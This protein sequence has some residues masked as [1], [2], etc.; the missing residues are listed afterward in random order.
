MRNSALTIPTLLAAGTL[1]LAGCGSSTEAQPAPESTPDEAL[2]EPSSE[3][4]FT[5]AH[6]LP[7]SYTGPRINAP[8]VPECPHHEE[9][10]QLEE[11]SDQIDLAFELGCEADIHGEITFS[12]PLPGNVVGLIS[13]DD[14]MSVQ[15]MCDGGYIPEEDCEIE[16]G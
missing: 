16:L 13:V 9:V 7:Q 12:E 8:A 2:A 11:V 3:D 10:G 5:P 15:Q 14:A 4:T 1:A 6:E